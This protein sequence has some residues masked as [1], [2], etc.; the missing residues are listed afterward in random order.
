MTGP[1]GEERTSE[2][3]K[4]CRWTRRGGSSSYVPFESLAPAWPGYMY[5]PL[6]YT[7]IIVPLIIYNWRPRL[8]GFDRRSIASSHV[9][10]AHVGLLVPLRS[11]AEV[12]GVRIGGV[13][14]AAAQRRSWKEIC[15]ELSPL[16]S[17]YFICIQSR[18]FPR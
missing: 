9:T 10:C 6:S 12:R 4:G 15:P 7:P 8:I 5:V 18:P 11:D 13:G 2:R 3:G 1:H 17:H 16:T 14:S